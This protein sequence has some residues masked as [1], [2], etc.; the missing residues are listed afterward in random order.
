MEI[1][2]QVLRQ[3]V[4]SSSIVYPT[5]IVDV[6]FCTSGLLGTCTWSHRSCDFSAILLRFYV[7]STYT[8]FVFFRIAT[9]TRSLVEHWMLPVIVILYT[10]VTNLT[11][12]QHDQV[13]PPSRCLQFMTSVRRVSQR[14]VS[15]AKYADWFSPMNHWLENYWDEAQPTVLTFLC[16]QSL[17]NR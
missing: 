11:V 13:A 5:A 1:I 12:V 7:F 16:I 17:C 8:Y 4:N 9:R 6:E 10:C 2:V 3:S 15:F 14:W